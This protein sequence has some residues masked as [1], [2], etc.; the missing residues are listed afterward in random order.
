M[1]QDHIG[2]IRLSTFAANSAGEFDSALK[3]LLDEGATSLIVDLRANT[4][5]LVDTSVAITSDFIKSG[6][7][8][9]EEWGNG[10]RDQYTAS[11]KTIDTEIPM[12][13]L[14]DGGTA[15]ASEIMAGAL[16]DYGRAKLIGTKTYG[17]GLIQNWIPLINNNGAMR[18]TIARWLTPKEQKIQGNGLKPDMVVE[19]TD[20]DIKALNDVQLKAAIDYLDGVQKSASQAENTN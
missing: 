20:E 3:A 18:V 8:L 13:V 7:I 9:I 11:G 1:L 14:V 2:Y 15:S 12:V 6:T 19:L 10:S 5:G 17:K 4:G 16:Q